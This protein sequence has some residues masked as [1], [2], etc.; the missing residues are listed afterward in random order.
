[1]KPYPLPDYQQHNEF[2]RNRNDKEIYLGINTGINCVDDWCDFY[3]IKKHKIGLYLGKITFQTN[4]KGNLAPIYIPSNI[5]NIERQV[6]KINSLWLDE[7]NK[8]YVKPKSTFNRVQDTAKYN[9][10]NIKVL[11]KRTKHNTTLTK[12]QTISYFMTLHSLN[13]S[14]I[15]NYI[16]T[17]NNNNGITAY[18]LHNKLYLALLQQNILQDNMFQWYNNNKAFSANNDANLITLDYLKANN[19]SNFKI[20]LYDKLFYAYLVWSLKEYVML[21][22]QG[23]IA[24]TNNFI[25]NLSAYKGNKIIAKFIETHNNNGTPFMQVFSY[26]ELPQDIQ[27][28]MIFCRN[29]YLIDP[30]DGFFHIESL[31]YVQSNEKGYKNVNNNS[32]STPNNTT[33]PALSIYDEEQEPIFKPSPLGN[34]YF[35]L[36]DSTNTFIEYYQ[37]IYPSINTL[38]KH[39][40][41]E[42][43]AKLDL[44]L[45]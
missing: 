42:M 35:E 45:N 34:Y 1:M 44:T 40:S 32:F 25:F 43:I 19:Q 20:L 3:K 7:I 24:E 12:E 9:P 18:V 29:A 27:D 17:I 39:W 14:F 5:K 2:L 30:R 11:C 10:N 38:P 23:Y 16:D 6:D 31:N 15:K 13:T 21:Y 22:Y 36:S 37:R 33:K 41:K 26:D 4:T 28:E 8:D